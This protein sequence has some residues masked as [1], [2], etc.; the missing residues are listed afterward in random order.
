MTGDLHPESPRDLEAPRSRF[1]AELGERLEVLR[2][3]LARLASG[4]ESATE[5]NALRRRLHALAAAAEVLGFASSSAALGNA[6]ENLA[7]VALRGSNAAV[8]E[9][10]ARV[11][12]VLPSLVLGADIDLETE[13]DASGHEAPGEPACIIVYGD[14]SL[15]S[16][17]HLPGALHHIESHATREASQA[18]ELVGQLSPDVLLVDGDRPELPELLPHLRQVAGARQLAIVAVGSFEQHAGLARLLRLGVARVLPK[19]ADALTLQRTLRRAA[20]APSTALS[21]ARHAQAAPHI[22]EP[23]STAEDLVKLVTSEARTAFRDPSVPGSGPLLDLGSGSEVLAALWSAFARVRA[24]AAQAS[25]GSSPLPR[26]G[27]YGALPVALGPP[28]PNG[29]LP[30]RSAPVPLAGRRLV[31]ADDDIAVRTLLAQALSELGATVLPARHGADALELCEKHWPDALVTDTLMP[32][33]D[34]FELSRQLRQDIALSDLPVLLIAWREHL[35]ECTRQPTG[36]SALSHIDGEALTRALRDA[37]ASRVAL[38]Q[39]LAQ[40]DAVHGRLDGLTPRLLLQMVCSRSPNALLSLR[41]G[42]LGFEFSIA[43]GRPVHARWYEAEAQRAEGTAVLGPFLGVRTGRFSVEPLFSPPAARFEGDVMDVLGPTVR[44]ARHAAQLVRP[45][46]LSGIE[47]VVLEPLVAEHHA[48]DAPMSRPLIAE[49]TRGVRPRDLAGDRSSEAARISA[50]LGDLA[51]RGAILGLLDGAGRDLIAPDTPV[52]DP[53]PRHVATVPRATTATRVSA[54]PGAPMATSVAAI[55]LRDAVLQAVA[56]PPLDAPEAAQDVDRAAAPAA[57]DAQDETPAD[58]EVADTGSDRGAPNDA[59]AAPTQARHA[60]DS[61]ADGSVGS[62]SANEAGFEESGSPD[63]ES[64]ADAP[65]HENAALVAALT[66]AG[67]KEALDSQWPAP[68]GARWRAALGPLI[69]TLLAGLL[70]FAGIRLF[71]EDATRTSPRTSSA[72]LP[73][74]MP[75]AARPSPATARTLDADSG[76]ANALPGAATNAQAS[77]AAQRASLSQESLPLATRPHVPPGQGVL[78]VHAWAPQAIY[79]GGVFM[80]KT[81]T[82]VVTLRPGSYQVR[83]GSEDDSPT[84][85]VEVKAGRRTRVSARLNDGP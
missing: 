45:G 2:Q 66:G 41:S 17:L 11:L 59:T 58:S 23:R 18:L 62:G 16:L 14:A 36:A 6:E 54:A 28:A 60:Q 47:R 56:E 69:V 1:I 81:D 49:L 61:G 43:D 26:E 79:V 7:S 10:V 80:G 76:A 67:A 77:L 57:E 24:L 78:E 12:D 31:V 63:S 38:E 48:S 32:E 34:G 82:R 46:A 13:L 39:R 52:V 8:R 64:A 37:L 5:L 85:E 72:P 74:V 75:A 29:S 20:L 68:R 40:H 35:L 30:P 22:F 19:P 53:L 25:G 73:A 27:P 55:E 9:R 70:A 44:R 83:V 42:D 3:G 33:L 65:P 50:L 21:S 71:A 15:E 4:S 84:L 51:R